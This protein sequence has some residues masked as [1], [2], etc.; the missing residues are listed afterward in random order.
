MITRY[1]GNSVYA[2]YD[3][4]EICLIA[5]MEDRIYLDLNA[6][7]NLVQFIST[8]QA[9]QDE[10]LPQ[11]DAENNLPDWEWQSLHNWVKAN[12]LYHV[13]G[14]IITSVS[15]ELNQT[16]MDHN[17]SVRDALNVTLAKLHQAEFELAAL[18]KEKEEE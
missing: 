16:I 9:E 10:G 18:R 5:N 6:L 8:F 12:P 4:Q 3:G 13:S 7:E 15:D 1:L 11:N 2:R 14:T 17:G